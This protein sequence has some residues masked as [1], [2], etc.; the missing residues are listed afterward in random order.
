MRQRFLNS[1]AVMIGSYVTIVALMS[2][3]ARWQLG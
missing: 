1:S 2:L 3:V